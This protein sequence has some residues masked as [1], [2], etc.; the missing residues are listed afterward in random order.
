MRP[1]LMLTCGILFV[2]SVAM[3]DDTPT[4][5]CANGAGT[6]VIGVIT[7]H[8]YCMSNNSMNWWNAYAWCDAQGRR[9]ISMDDCACSASVNCDGKCAEF[10][11]KLG[12]YAWTATP[13][14]TSSTA[15]SLYISTTISNFSSSTSRSTVQRYSICY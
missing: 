9:L 3:A 14:D 1:F 10:T 11:Q 15:Y 5:T 4:E 13:G 6:V 8:K 7:G 2:T 12:K